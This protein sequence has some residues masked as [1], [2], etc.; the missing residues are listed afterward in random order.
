MSHKLGHKTGFELFIGPH[1]ADGTPASELLILLKTQ[2]KALMIYE[3]TDLDLSSES[4]VSVLSRIRHCVE[5]RCELTQLAIRAL[6]SL[7]L[8]WILTLVTKRPEAVSEAVICSVLDFWSILPPPQLASI[9]C[10]R[11]LIL[12]A[13]SSSPDITWTR[14]GELLEALLRSGLVSA[15]TLEDN[16]LSLLQLAT[17]DTEVVPHLKRLSETL[18]SITDNLD[19]KDMDW[20]QKILSDFLS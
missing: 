10:P 13:M 9:L 2:T 16:C 18:R 5:T 17:L 6:E 8:D 3:R 19:R 14:A 1:E 15:L 20:V 4:L 12:L 7:T 11:N